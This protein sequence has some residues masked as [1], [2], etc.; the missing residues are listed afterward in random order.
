MC[1]KFP[2]NSGDY[3]GVIASSTRHKNK[4]MKEGMFLREVEDPKEEKLEL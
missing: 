1:T 2:L 4:G 3:V